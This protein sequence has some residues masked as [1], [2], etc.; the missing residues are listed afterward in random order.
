MSMLIL[1]CSNREES[2][3]LELSKKLYSIG[4]HKGI[5]TDLHDLAR[6]CPDLTN[7]IYYEESNWTSSMIH[8]QDSHIMPE[9]KFLFVIPEYNGSYP[10]ILKLWLDILSVRQRQAS[11]Y[12]KKVAFIGIS[13]GKASNIRGLDHFMGVTRYLKMISLPTTLNIPNISKVLA[14]WSDDGDYSGRI[15]NF[16]D[17]FSA[18]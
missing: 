13:E 4:L 16:L 18:F 14:D 6:F 7:P 12:H 8:Y 5:Q 9:Q 2:K 15:I 11:F 17:E 3:S 1:S 10:G